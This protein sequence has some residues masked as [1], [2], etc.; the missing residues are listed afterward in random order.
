M[1]PLGPTC[2]ADVVSHRLFCMLMLMLS[3][4]VLTVY[5]VM[6]VKDVY[7]MV[8]ISY[9]IR[10]VI[11]ITH[12]NK[13]LVP[14]HCIDTI[15]ASMSASDCIHI[16]SLVW[17]VKSAAVGHEILIGFDT[18]AMWMVIHSAIKLRAVLKVHHIS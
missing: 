11:F 2:M 8:I 1:G 13:L 18:L 15:F 10:L 7:C 12:L 6:L 3:I 17:V 9:C 4:M 14:M 5:K 16:Y